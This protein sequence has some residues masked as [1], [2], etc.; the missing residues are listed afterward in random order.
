MDKQRWPEFVEVAREEDVRA[1]LSVPL[2]VDSADPRQHGELVG[3]LNIYSRNVLAF[4]PFDEGLMR[5]YTVAASQ[6]ITLARR[7][8]HSRETVI[9]L[10]KALTSR[11]EIDQA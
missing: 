5:L 4:D 3:S 1:S 7:W 6:A 10:E 8:Q 2:I 9:R 11:T